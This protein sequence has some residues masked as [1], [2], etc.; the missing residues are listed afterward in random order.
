[1]IEKLNIFDSLPI[2]K[3]NEK[4]F[5]IFKNENIRIEKIVSNGQ[6]SLEKFLVWPKNEFILLLQGDAILEVIENNDIK[7]I[8]LKTGDYLDIKAH[9]KHRVAYTSESKTTIWL[10]I[11]YWFIGITTLNNAPV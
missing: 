6:K 5:E 11:F 4:F 10:A 1:M 3:E 9:V 8:K 7:E 2:D